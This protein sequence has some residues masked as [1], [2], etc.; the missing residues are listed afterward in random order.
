MF[1][2]PSDRRDNRSSNAFLTSEIQPAFARGIGQR[3]HAA[4][5]EVAA[6]IEHDLLD[7]LRGGAFGDQFADR[8]RR[9][10]VGAGLELARAGPSRA[11]RRDAT[12]SPLASS[13]TCA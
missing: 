9:L 5:I 8:L 6:A 3:L 1:S 12:V 13:I 10:D 2:F 4:V 11:R 7:A